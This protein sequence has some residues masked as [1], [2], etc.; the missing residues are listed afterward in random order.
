MSRLGQ[1]FSTSLDAIGITL[2]DGV[3]WR[4]VDDVKLDDYCFSDGI[5]RISP[6]LS[7]EVG[8]N[9]NF[10]F[11]ISLRESGL[12]LL[13][14]MLGSYAILVCFV[15]CSPAEQLVSFLGVTLD[16]TM[17][18]WFCFRLLWVVVIILHDKYCNLSCQVV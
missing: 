15:S 6:K 17:L 5:G 7:K 3:T 12:T 18:L 10:S 2:E 4:M 1:C 14:V 13:K 11:V 9:A 8:Y 16:R